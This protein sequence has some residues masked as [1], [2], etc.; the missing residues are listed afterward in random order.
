MVEVSTT[1]IPLNESLTTKADKIGLNIYA[2]IGGG[3]T[4]L[5]VIIAVSLYCIKRRTEDDYD[6][7]E[8]DDFNNS[9]KFSETTDI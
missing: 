2:L 6:S 9:Y 4:L 3:S 8:D 1:N 5:V 7:D